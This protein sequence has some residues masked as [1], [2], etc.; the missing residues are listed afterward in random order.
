MYGHIYEM[1]QAVAEGVKDGG[2]N[3]YIKRVKEWLPDDVLEKMQAKDSN[4]KQ[5]DVPVCDP[6]ELVEYDAIIFG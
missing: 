5:Q 2:G 3:A 1:A 6:K 4:K